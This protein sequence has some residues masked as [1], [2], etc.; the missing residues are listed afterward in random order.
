MLYF[1]GSSPELQRHTE[2][3]DKSTHDKS[4][5]SVKKKRLQKKIKKA[6]SDQ[7]NR[8]GRKKVELIGRASSDSINRSNLSLP[9]DKHEF[10]IKLEKT[11]S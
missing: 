4:L 2:S 3:S 6:N 7:V 5:L 10:L 8:V 9:F 1:D 11:L